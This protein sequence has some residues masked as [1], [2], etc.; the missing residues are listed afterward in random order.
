MDRRWLGRAP[1]ATLAIWIIAGVAAC[2]GQSCSCI[3]PLKGGFPVAQ[4]RENGVQARVTKGFFDFA[5]QNALTLVPA[6]LPGGTLFN[7]PPS[8]GGANQV[9][10]AMPPPMCRLSLDPRDLALTPTAPNKV[11]FDTRLV[12]K[13][14]D[15][16]PI[17]ASFLGI[18]AHCL[19]SIDTTRAGPI[20]MRLTGDVVLPVDATTHLTGL[21]LQNAAIT[22]LDDGDVNLN[23]P[24][25][26]GACTIV[27]SGLVK[28]F[29]LGYVKGQVGTLLT[30]VIEGQGC[31]PCVDITDCSAGATACVTGRCI[32]P[33]MK[34]VQRLGLEGRADVG[35]FFTSSGRGPKAFMDV[36]EAAG[37]YVQADTGLSLG[38]LGG[39]QGDP[40]SAC[41]PLVAAPPSVQ[42][43]P[44][45][46]FQGDT[47]P[48]T[49]TPYHIGIGIH[50]S[51]LTQLGYG[52]WDGGGLCFSL[53][54]ER[55]AQI[56]AKT[57]SLVMPS[58]L[59]L[60]HGEDAPMRVELRPQNPPSFVFGKGTF[61]MN[62]G[63]KVVDEPLVTMTAKDLTADFSLFI[64]D[65]YVRVASLTGDIAL[66]FNLDTDMNGAVV[67][68]AGDLST[69]VTNVRVDK[70]ELLAE[71]HAQLQ[72]TFPTI[73]AAA[74]APL[75]TAFGPF[76][77]PAVAGLKIRPKAFAQTDLD[78]SGHG[79]FLGIFAD[80]ST[81]NAITRPTRTSAQ[82]VSVQTPPTEVFSVRG[83]DGRVPSVTLAV[84]GDADGRPVE[85]SWSMDGGAWRP[86]QASGTLTITDPLLWLQG[87][88]AVRVRSRAVGDPDSLDPQPVELRFLIDSEAPR[89]DFTVAG[90]RVVPHATDGVS[91][92]AALRYR[93]DG[94][95]W[96]TSDDLLLPVGRTAAA[97][98]VE[99]TDEAG[100]VATLPFRFDGPT[101][102]VVGCAAAG[103]AP[104][105]T[106]LALGLALVA[107]A[108]A[109]RRR[110][111]A[112]LAVALA[113]PAAGC[114]H[115]PGDG[116]RLAPT[117]AVGRTHDAR[118]RDGALQIAAYDA[119]YGDLAY[120]KIEV[121]HLGEPVDWL[122]VDGDDPS[123]PRESDSPYRHGHSSPGP[124]VGAYAALALTSG[125]DPRIAYFDRT[126]GAVKFARGGFPFETHEI[127][128]GSDDGS[129]VVGPFPAI[130]LDVYDLPTVAYMAI[131][132]G[133]ASGFRAE[134]R[135]A[136]ARTDSPS[137]H[138][139][140]SIAVVD[141]TPIS[142]GGRC[143][144]NSACV[145]KDLV[146]MVANTN[147]A[148]SSCVPVDLAPCPIACKDTAA[149]VQ[150]VCKLKAPPPVAGELPPGTGLF[151]KLVRGPGGKVALVYHDRSL[152]QLRVAVDDGNGKFLP[153]V[154]D[155]QMGDRDVGQF[156]TAAYDEGGVLHVAYKD[157]GAGQLLYRS[158]STAGTPSQAQVVDDGLREDGPHAVG[159][160]ASIV[161]A[162]A[163][164]RVLYQDQATSDLLLA[165]KPGP[166][167]HTTVRGGADGSGFSSH[168]LDDGAAQYLTSWVFDRGQTPFGRLVLEAVAR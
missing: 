158:I 66:P 13:T 91:D 164:P 72:A 65:R 35:S 149:C 133:D 154:I 69:A 73:F 165:D 160:S 101:L 74:L 85:W 45:A 103:R 131:G 96:A 51:H 33:D 54:T 163:Q 36:M 87:R 147:P 82:I 125:G 12:V 27:N 124:D 7:I 31:Q 106:P 6:L 64:D 52:L 143:V 112:L 134:L 24:G 25:S 117:D 50:V 8:C 115:G 77:L 81:T 153:A 57:L 3:Q 155:G 71:T 123:S 55:Y 89:G 34:C 150:G 127:D 79:Q 120:G 111:A 159:A 63:M 2:G 109:R 110:A 43:A 92:A 41:V 17:D 142:C 130:T 107:L 99:V 93:V 148:Q 122:L 152:G 140:W 56:S 10:C 118:L 49:S 48:G 104:G 86:Y 19:I 46:T 95:A 168:L 78:A 141:S 105:G 83:R 70:T 47:I 32:G 1:L 84:G 97:A 121:A 137:S 22:D 128:R 29:V 162:G 67:L 108:L 102:P 139:D 129:V 26:S 38:V 18:S 9:C 132:L 76:Q 4:R 98:R 11:A 136:R 14:L 59:D 90:S 61:T 166:W 146:G 60:I 94:G 23:E 5:S 135:V 144:A 114:H 126:A 30:S 53:G 44:S 80:A 113:V 28:G 145:V 100:N 161:V 16:L 58:L 62:G 156:A 119:N 21:S 40:H 88:H 20:T 68:V 75:F 37:G 42:V 39:A 167:V 15:N 157:A 138:D 116:D 151:A